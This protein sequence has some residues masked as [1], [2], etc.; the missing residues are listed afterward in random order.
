MVLIID[1]LAA[2]LHATMARTIPTIKFI[3]F[4]IIMP[5]PI[6]VMVTKTTIW[7]KVLIMALMEMTMMLTVLM[8]VV[9]VVLVV[10]VV[11]VVT[12][13]TKMI[14]CN[15]WARIPCRVRAVGVYVPPS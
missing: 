4:V 7:A 2:L 5:M 9:V 12:T 14:I 10:V 6:I 8:V 15:R 11:V 13:M 1:F 3:N